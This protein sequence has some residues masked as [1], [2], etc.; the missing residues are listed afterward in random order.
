MN[1]YFHGLQY[2][3]AGDCATMISSNHKMTYDVV[4][5]A[6]LDDEDEFEPKGQA[7]NSTEWV[8]RD[9]LDWSL[10]FDEDMDRKGIPISWLAVES[11]QEGEQ[12]YREHTQMP[13]CMIH[14]IAR[15]YWGD[16]LKTADHLPKKSGRKKKTDETSISV[17]HGTFHVQFD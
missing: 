13:E 3:E 10:K 1:D 11:L 16:G 5:S 15:Y 7:D 6:L 2:N 12:W 8:D 9:K 4:P 14:Y 17:N